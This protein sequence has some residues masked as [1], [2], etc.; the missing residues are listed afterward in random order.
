MWTNVSRLDLIF[1]T[2]DMTYCKIKKLIRLTNIALC[3]R[4]ISC[5]VWVLKHLRISSPFSEVQSNRDASSTAASCGFDWWNISQRAFPPFTIAFANRP[6][7]RLRNS[8]IHQ[9][10]R[11][12]WLVLYQSY[13]VSIR[14]EL[15][16]SWLRWH[17][18]NCFNKKNSTNLKKLFLQCFK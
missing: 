11:L 1:L 2:S 16:T 7:N 13:V 17:Q 6:N 3:F 10:L 14:C 18:V 12:T 4:T 15:L 8:E 5:W 9:F